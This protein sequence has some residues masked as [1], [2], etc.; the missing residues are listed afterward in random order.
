[1]RKSIVVAAGGVALAG[2]AAAAYMPDIRGYV[3]PSVRAADTPGLVLRV[4]SL[5]FAPFALAW[6]HRRLNIRP[7]HI[8]VFSAS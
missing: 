4:I 3:W 6:P 2:V 5:A 8:G 7:R 1:M